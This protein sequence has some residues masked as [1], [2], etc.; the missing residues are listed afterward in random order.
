MDVQSESGEE[1]P[2]SSHDKQQRNGERSVRR[3]RRGWKKREK[4][5]EN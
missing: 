2:E 4:D 3:R 5:N 1:S